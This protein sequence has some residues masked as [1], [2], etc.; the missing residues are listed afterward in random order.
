MSLHRVDRK[1]KR[2]GDLF[3]GL[4]E[5]VLE[6]HHAALDG[7][8]LREARH[9][10]LYCLPPHHHLRRVY[11][12]RIGDL[13][14]RLDGLGRADRAAAQQVQRAIMGDAKQP[15]AERRGILQFLHGDEGPGESVLHHILAIDH[16]AHQARAV[17]VQLRPQ[18]SGQRQELGLA[19]RR[20]RRW[21]PV[22]AASPSRTVI[23]VSP[24]RPKAKPVA[25]RGSSSTATTWSPNW[26]GGIGAPNWARYASRSMPIARA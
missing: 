5:H 18:L 9:R 12:L 10:R 21:T 22:H 1:A 19:R 4:V 17:T 16:R 15:G 20:R 14:R 3:E 2:G 6:D 23:P 25:Y 26:R 13:V 8:K 7:R 11:V 24:F